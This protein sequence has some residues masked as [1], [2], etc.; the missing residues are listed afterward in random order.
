[1]ITYN[2]K[3]IIIN[4]YSPNV[5]NKK[6][7]ISHCMFVPKNFPEGKR[8]T[9][10]LNCLYYLNYIMHVRKQAIHPNFK[11]HHKCPAHI[12]PYLWF[13]ITSQGEEILSHK[14]NFLLVKYSNILERFIYNIIFKVVIFKETLRYSTNKGL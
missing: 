5:T 3:A 6:T 2:F 9:K 13:F 12:F 10:F 8:R 14:K 1:M 11:Q 4:F 7:V